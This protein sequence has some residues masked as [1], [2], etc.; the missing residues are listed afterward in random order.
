MFLLLLC[1]KMALHAQDVIVKT[2]Q[3]EIKAKVTE[4]TD[5]AIKYKKW[6]N[7]DGPLYNISK[8]EVFMIIYANGKRETIVQQAAA[9][10]A[11]SLQYH[12]AKPVATNNPPIAAGLAPRPTI[13][14]VVDYKNVR[15][16]YAPSHV[17]Y[18]FD[19]SPTTLG[20]HS[21]L[22]IIKNVLNFGGGADYFFITGAQQTMY[23]AYLS[24]YLPLNRLTKNYKKQDQGLFLF[25]TIGYASISHEEDGY[26]TS[27]GDMTAGIGLDY[28]FTKHLGLSVSADKFGDGKFSFKGAICF[29]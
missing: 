24:P 13:D 9:V 3:V 18:W 1:S 8:A 7:L 10:P 27:K 5:A 17:V 20:V 15:V 19:S 16:K 23:S 6:D 14:T 22:R 29:K 12:P 21:Q 28:F 11:S 26:T 25:A 2:D 4:I